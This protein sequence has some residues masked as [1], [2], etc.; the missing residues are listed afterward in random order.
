MT[1]Q[2]ETQAMRI[3]NLRIQLNKLEAVNF[4]LEDKI[5]FLS[6]ENIAIKEELETAKKFIEV[7]KYSNSKLCQKLDQVDEELQRTKNDLFKLR[8]S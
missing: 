4:K 8:N 1:H 6:E 7:W 2:E 3:V 5:T